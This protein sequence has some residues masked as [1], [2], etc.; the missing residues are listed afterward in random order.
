MGVNSVA[1]GDWKLLNYKLMDELFAQ[2]NIVPDIFGTN[3]ITG[4][5]NPVDINNFIPIKGSRNFYDYTHPKNTKVNFR[6]FQTP[7]SVSNNVINTLKSKLTPGNTYVN[8]KNAISQTINPLEGLFFYFSEDL[9][10]RYKSFEAN[11]KNP[12][13]KD[14]NKD[15]ILEENNEDNALNK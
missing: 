13:V 7:L 8:F 5:P 12:D 6:V 9:T 11:N 15:K 14:K 10:D 1:Q 4:I 2:K 3:E